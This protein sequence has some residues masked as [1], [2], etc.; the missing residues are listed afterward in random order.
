[1]TAGRRSNW[2]AWLIII[3]TAVAVY[4]VWKFLPAYQ[5]AW[6]VDDMLRTGATQA[7]RLARLAE[8][9]RTKQERELVEALVNRVIGL[10]IR[11]PRPVVALEYHPSQVSVSCDY[12]V[13]IRHPVIR[14][15]T[16]LDMHRVVTTE[17]KRVEWE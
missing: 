6:K 4:W 16:V 3:G 12:T 17:L 5:T 2:L 11:G 13:E 15:F 14:R 8:P 1:M 10:G 9:Q 7:Y